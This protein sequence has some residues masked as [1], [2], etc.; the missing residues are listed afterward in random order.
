MEQSKRSSSAF[1]CGR[2][3]GEGRSTRNRRIERERVLT[4][5]STWVRRLTNHIRAYP[6]F[7]VYERRDFEEGIDSGQTE[8]RRCLRAQLLVLHWTPGSVPLPRGP[9]R[10]LKSVALAVDCF[11]FLYS[12]CVVSELRTLDGGMRVADGRA[13]TY[14]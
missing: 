2:G 14:Y 3:A 6:L 12:E 7:H 8:R 4:R 1:R 10:Y 5:A 11:L 13:Y 9:F